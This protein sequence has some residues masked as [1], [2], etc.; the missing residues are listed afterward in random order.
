[1][2]FH[3]I[4]ITRK[5][6]N[7]KLRQL[8]IKYQLFTCGDNRAYCQMFEEAETITDD[9][10]VALALFILDHS[11]TDR[12]LT[13]ICYLICTEAMSVYVDGE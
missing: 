7:E 6:N 10:V 13:N 2:K 3:N 8:C 5:V 12:P 1:M 4:T 9:T 11:N